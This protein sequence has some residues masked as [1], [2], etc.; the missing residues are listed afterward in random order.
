MSHSTHVGFNAPPSPPR[1]EITT[2]TPREG[3]TP[4]LFASLSAALTLSP[5]CFAIPQVGVGH[6]LTLTTPASFPFFAI[7]Q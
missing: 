5:A 4:F 6:D 7:F 1:S 2:A 3:A